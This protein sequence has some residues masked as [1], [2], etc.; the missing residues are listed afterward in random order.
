MIWYQVGI[1]EDGNLTYNGPTSRFHAGALGTRSLVNDDEAIVHQKESLRSQYSLIESV[2]RPLIAAKP[3]I[4]ETGVSSTVGLALLDIYWTWLHPLHNCVYRP[5]LIMDLALGGP[6]CSNFLLMCI[7][8]LAARHLP[9]QSQGPLGVTN[10]H[11]FVLQAKQLLLEEMASSIPS[12]P[13]IQGLLILSGVHCAMGKSSEGWLYTGMA[14]RMMADVGL[15]LPLNKLAALESRTPAEWETRRRLYNSA[16]IWDK[17]LSLALGR[18]PSLTTPPYPAEDILD[19]YDDEIVWKPLHALEVLE[20][21]SPFRFFNTSVFCAFASLHEVTT[22]MLL[23]LAKPGSQDNL[24]AQI[25]DL[26]KRFH[27]WYTGLPGELRL[28]DPTGTIQ[29]PPPHIVSLK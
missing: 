25:S 14:F 18:P 21:L 1:G 2:W 12:I 28:D 8:G 6:Y 5:V 16:Y 3:F 24:A 23:F 10:A 22:D 4:G 11:Q 29:S 27:K 19:K 17:T 26:D 20:T 7:F 13:T 15:H 9:D